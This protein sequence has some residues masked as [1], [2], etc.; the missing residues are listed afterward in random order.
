LELLEERRE[1]NFGNVRINP[2]RASRYGTVSGVFSTGLDLIMEV[3][4]ILYLVVKQQTSMSIILVYGMPE[5]ILLKLLCLKIYLVS[6]GDLWF[7]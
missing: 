3:S 4:G 7:P 6:H 1:E 2:E 5:I